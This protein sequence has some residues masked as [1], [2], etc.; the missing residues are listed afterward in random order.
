MPTLNT[1]SVKP[2]Q[3]EEIDTFAQV[4]QS[5]FI[6]GI[7]S[8]LLNGGKAAN[9]TTHANLVQ[10]EEKSFRTDTSTRYIKAVDTV[11]GDT[12]A[13]A[14]WNFFLK[15]QTPEQLDRTLHI[16]QPG[17]EGHVA[18]ESPILQHLMGSRREV[19]GTRPFIYLHMLATHPKHHRRGAGGKLVEWG[20]LQADDLKL[21]MYLEASPEARPV[22]ERWGFEMVKE[23]V[24]DMDQFDRTD[25]KGKA[26]LNTVMMRQVKKKIQ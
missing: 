16:P 13:V 12:I 22:Y 24:F 4:T 2:L 18:S 21:P 8:V 11:T 20:V 7:G 5:A 14:K 6:T 17:E 3:V 26:D 23:V 10:V 25:L 9:P 19:M 1:I 15:E